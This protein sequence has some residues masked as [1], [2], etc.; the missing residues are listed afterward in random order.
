MKVPAPF[1]FFAALRHPAQPIIGH[2]AE[3]AGFEQV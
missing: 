3:N 2:V 1:C